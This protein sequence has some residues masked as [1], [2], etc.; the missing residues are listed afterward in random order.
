MLVDFKKTVDIMQ[1]ETFVSNIFLFILFNSQ[2][3]L[4]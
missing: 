4:I 3:V 2:S 1:A